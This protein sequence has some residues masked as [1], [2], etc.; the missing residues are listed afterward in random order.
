MLPT[1][2]HESADVPAGRLL[3]ELEQ[4]QDDAI[5]QLDE[6]ESR[7]AE[8][9]GSLDMEMEDLVDDETH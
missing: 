6:L 7:L 2:L 3:S 9:L 4:R 8:V 5:A 1:S